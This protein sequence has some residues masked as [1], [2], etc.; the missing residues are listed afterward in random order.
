MLQPSLLMQ[1]LSSNPSQVTH[2]QRTTHLWETCHG[3]SFT[4]QHHWELMGHQG[5]SI[6]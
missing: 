1:C 6:S 4:H 3:S 2:S 5:Q